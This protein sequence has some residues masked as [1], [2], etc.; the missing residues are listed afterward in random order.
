[1]MS[2]VRKRLS[3]TGDAAVVVRAD[4]GDCSGTPLYYPLRKGEIPNRIDL[5]CARTPT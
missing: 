1:M 3:D 2:D 4:L 5:F